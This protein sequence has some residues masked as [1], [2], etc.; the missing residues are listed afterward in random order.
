M[1]KQP[2]RDTGP[3]LALRRELHRVGLRFRTH[4]K[5]QF[6]LHRF[7]RTP[8]F[9]A[10]CTRCPYPPGHPVHHERNRRLTREVDIVLPR[11]RLVVFVDGCFW[12]RCPE[13]YPPKACKTNSEWW[14]AKLER[15]VRRD[16]ETDELL[17]AAGWAVARVWE[18]EDMSSCAAE[19]LE[20][21]RSADRSGWLSHVRATMRAAA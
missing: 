19:I 20:W 5:F 11:H 14:E 16:G 1:Q 9:G 18:H 7:E 13:H 10:F 4:R 17:N 6:E 2:S 12:H 8:G 21:T 15:N 3:E